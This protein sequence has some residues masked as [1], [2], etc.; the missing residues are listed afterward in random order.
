MSP[1]LISVISIA[2]DIILGGGLLAVWLKYRIQAR[3]ADRVDF[4]TVLAEVKSQRNEAWAHIAEQVRRIENMEAEIQGLRIAR[5]LDPFPNWLVDLQGR[6]LYANRAFEALFL[7]PKGQTYRDIIGKTHI[8]VWPE[9]FCRTI[10]ALNSAAGKRPD[11]TARANA[12]LDIPDLGRCSVTVHKFPYRIK[13][14]ILAY[15]GY[16][17]VIDPDMQRLGEQ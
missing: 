13:G 12:S 7:E 9:P 10:K 15:A 2:L 1:A 6:F 3:S 16:I 11:G 5:D 8:D 17:T 14:V 4:E